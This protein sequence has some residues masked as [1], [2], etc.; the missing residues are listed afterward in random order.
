MATW[1]LYS[2]TF[3]PTFSTLLALY[4]KQVHGNFIWPGREKIVAFDLD[5]NPCTF[6]VVLVLL[7]VD[8]PHIENFV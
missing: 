8:F 6:F 1:K 2:M 5:I 4:G 7:I 3:L